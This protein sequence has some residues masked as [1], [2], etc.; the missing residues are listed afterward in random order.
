[1]LDGKGIHRLWRRDEIQS[2]KQV[3]NERSH[4]LLF[5]WASSEVWCHSISNEIKWNAIGI[6]H[7]NERFIRKSQNQFYRISQ[8]CTW[9][10]GAINNSINI[11]RSQYDEHHF[12]GALSLPDAINTKRALWLSAKRCRMWPMPLN[13]IISNEIKAMTSIGFGSYCVSGQVGCLLRLKYHD[14]IAC[15]WIN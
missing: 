2:R 6:L 15:G 7:S 1:M 3:G 4:Y 10:N 9:M 8:I 14:G 12:N 13:I 11:H 5:R